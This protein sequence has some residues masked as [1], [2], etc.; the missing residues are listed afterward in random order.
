MGNINTSVE[1]R[2]NFSLSLGM[3][4]KERQLTPD[5][6]DEWRKPSKEKKNLLRILKLPQSHRPIKIYYGTMTFPLIQA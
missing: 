2:E 4:E 3:D 1:R 6:N 5:I